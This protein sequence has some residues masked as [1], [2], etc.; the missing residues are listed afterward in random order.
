MPPQRAG[1]E[2]ATAYALRL[3]TD[4]PDRTIRQVENRDSWMKCPYAGRDDTD[5]FTTGL[6][7]RSGQDSAQR[8]KAR[9]LSFAQAPALH[10]LA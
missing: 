8:M 5:R 9:V 7:P 1:P 3:K 6:I 4:G 10:P 2:N